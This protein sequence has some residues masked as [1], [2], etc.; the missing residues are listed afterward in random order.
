MMDYYI[1]CIDPRCRN[2][3]ITGMYEDGTPQ[4]EEYAPPLAFKAREGQELCRK[5]NTLGWIPILVAA[6]KYFIGSDRYK[7]IPFKESYYY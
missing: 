7:N 6:D 2:R 5:L 3:W 4:F 1:S